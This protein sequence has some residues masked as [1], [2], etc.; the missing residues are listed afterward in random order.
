MKITDLK[1]GSILKDL[2]GA[3]H[4]VIRF[5]KGFVI[6]T[7]GNGENWLLPSHLEYEELVRC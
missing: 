3:E 1:V 2:N 5:E 7:Y 6:T 4:K